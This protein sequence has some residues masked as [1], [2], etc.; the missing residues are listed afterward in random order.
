L[1]PPN[2]CLL[3]FLLQYYVV[4]HFI[5]F[6]PSPLRFESKERLGRILGMGVWLTEPLQHGSNSGPPFT[7]VRFTSMLK[8]ACS[9]Y[10]PGRIQLHKPRSPPLFRSAPQL[11]NTSMTRRLV[12]H[13]SLGRNRQRSHL[14][15]APENYVVR[16]ASN[17]RSNTGATTSCWPV[18]RRAS[19]YEI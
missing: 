2:T 14:F 13:H 15:L 10:D 11:S 16:L 12:F 5:E 17:P 4:V 18:Q 8:K 3:D 1:R 9:P 19:R 6:P 7:R